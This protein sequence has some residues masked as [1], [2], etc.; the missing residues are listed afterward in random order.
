MGM[1]LPA[2]YRGWRRKRLQRNLLSSLDRR[3]LSITLYHLEGRHPSAWW[4]SGTCGTSLNELRHQVKS[5]FLLLYIAILGVHV[6]RDGLSGT[7]DNL[8]G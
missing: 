5:S 8:R 7:P 6:R 2:R 3:G 1:A 4:C